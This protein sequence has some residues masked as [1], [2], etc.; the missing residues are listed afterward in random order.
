M[1]PEQGT[2]SR[3]GALRRAECLHEV[4]A[5]VQEVGNDVRAFLEKRPPDGGDALRD[6]VR[7]LAECARDKGFPEL[8]RRARELERDI[9]GARGPVLDE[10]QRADLTRALE[11]VESLAPEPPELLEQGFR[12][13]RSPEEE[14]R[15]LLLLGLEQQAGKELSRHLRSL[16]YMVR[17]FARAREV[18]GK[19]LPRRPWAVVVD[20][21]LVDDR[22]G[23]V[24]A[25][26][27][28]LGGEGLAPLLVVVNG[29]PSMKAMLRAARLGADTYLERP[30]DVNGLVDALDDL[31]VSG[32]QEPLRVLL[33]DDDEAAAQ[34]HQAVLEEAGME[35][36][37][38][39]DP[40]RVLDALVDHPADLVLMDLYMPGCS[41]TDLARVIHQKSEHVH[42]PVVF[43]SGEQDE[44]RQLEAISRAGDDFLPKNLRPDLF[45]AS[46]RSKA[47]RARSTRSRIVRDGL[48]GL[49]N[50]S[51]I[52]Q[53]LQHEVERA[54]RQDERFAFAMLDLDHFKT[55]NDTYGHPAGDLVLKR[56]AKVLRQRLRKTDILGRYGGEEFAVLLLGVEEG[57]QA[58]AIM[59]EIREFFGGLTHRHE[60]DAFHVTLSC[61]VAVFP[62]H[63]DAEALA[64]AA[65][66]ALYR[67]KQAGRD[68]VVLA[69]PPARD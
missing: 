40:M 42:L 44:V 63:A 27:H 2:C 29:R 69:E 54:T 43:F 13:V 60:D 28:N 55:V 48:T 58:R 12:P 4:R 47:L 46:V 7:G 61:G 39:S 59:D 38:V 41:G 45:A 64:E 56:L 16:G 11:A 67:A 53:M 35:T 6:K 8:E 65:D 66:Q 62:E 32:E 17:S 26:L 24:D 9:A 31:A 50:H 68:R 30:L 49:Y 14:R 33:V 21:A 23:V 22:E 36:A 57:G 1:E 18:A 15:L 5:R 10:R 34:R 51:S 20:A 52:K 3:L 25:L 19:T 37:V